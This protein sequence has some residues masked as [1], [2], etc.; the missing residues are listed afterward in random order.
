MCIKLGKIVKITSTYGIKST[1]IA[2]SASRK[3][4]MRLTKK[5]RKEGIARAIDKG[6]AI[7]DDID[8]AGDH[9]EETEKRIIDAARKVA[10]DIPAGAPGECAYCGERFIRLVNGACG[11]CRDE[12][13]LK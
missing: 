8:R 3:T 7:L 5:F 10:S 9:I 2:K 13:K 4:L 6:V 1:D 11:R 12:F